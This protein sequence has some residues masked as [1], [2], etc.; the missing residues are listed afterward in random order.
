M[1]DCRLRRVAHSQ[2]VP[3]SAVTAVTLRSVLPALLL[4]PL[5]LV[6]L[7]L[8]GAMIV[9]WRRRA[10]A[11]LVAASAIGLL[12]L[13]T[14]MASGLLRASLAR[15]IEGPAP[16]AAPRAIIVLG[17]EVARGATGPD[18]GPLT[19][20]RLRAAAALHRATGLPLLVS[21]GSLAAGEPP[22]ALLM[23]RSLTEDFRVPVR[24][25][26]EA[27][28]TT[29]ENATLSAAMLA[30]EGIDAAYLVT[31]AW[32]LPRAREE[33]TR[34]GLAVVPSPVRLDRVPQGAASDFLPRA[35]RLADSWWAIREWAG[36][37][38]RRL[39]G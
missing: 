22:L 19:L 29:G 28:R 14:P 18:V 3:Q 6:L 31:H 36:R 15:D 33:F 8:A 37:V 32:H 5:L 26:E 39:G 12:A 2:T 30:A 10:G 11:L 13:A 25:S 23:M 21:G 20:E 35:D 27:S 24:W 1:P 4:P 17:A 38:A 7:A 16:I 34:A 9:P